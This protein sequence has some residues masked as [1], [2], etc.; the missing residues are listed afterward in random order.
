M[1]K[2]KNCV[3]DRMLQEQLKR[4]EI[5]FLIEVSHYQDDFGCTKGVYYK[6]ICNATKMSY[7]TFYAAMHSL[8]EK[9]F[10]KTE[11]NYYG[12][13]D[14][15]ILNNDFSYPEAVKEGYVSTGHDIFYNAAFH[16][17]KAGEKLLALQFVKIAGAGK[18]YHIGVQQLYEKYCRLLDITER[19]LQV[20][21]GHL[22]S[23]FS[24]GIKNKMYWITPLVA[25]FKNNAPS[26]ANSFAGHLGRVACRR[27]RAVYTETTLR[28]ATD[29]IKQYAQT[30]RNN[31]ADI[32]IRAVTA[33]ISRTNEAVRDKRKWNRDLNPKYIHKIIRENI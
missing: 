21:L 16:K 7:E 2:L 32:F 4:S 12:D 9:G 15:T 3:V 6:D 20:Y 18:R 24:I 17:L 19:T 5:D 14:I 28:D 25:V 23:F 10:I 13:W 30:F 11:K 8:E 1:Q 29:L 33:S 27:N 26:D 22:R 31:M